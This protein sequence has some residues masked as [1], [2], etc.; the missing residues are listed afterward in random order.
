MGWWGDFTSGVENLV[1]NVGN[2]VTNTLDNVGHAIGPYMPTIAEATAAYFG[3]PYLGDALGISSTAAGATI[4]AGTSMATGGNPL[5]GAI[6]GGLGGYAGGGGFTSPDPMA[7]GA[8][9]PMISGAQSAAATGDMAQADALAQAAGFSSYQELA[10]TQTA[11]GGMGV[12]GLSPSTNMAALGAGGSGG[13]GMGGGAMMALGGLNAINQTRQ[14]QKNMQGYAAASNPLAPAQAGYAQ[15]LQ[16]LMNNP[17]GIVNMP[18]YQAGLQAVER[19]GAAGGYLG[20]GN[21][22][23]QLQQYGGNFYNNAINQYQG[24]A[25]ANASAPGQIMGNTYA[26][27]MPAYM[28]G[29]GMLAAPF[30]YNSMQGGANPMSGG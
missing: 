1:S 13:I 15:Q 4:G 30:I 9:D 29:L 7:G 8:T 24:A 17:N 27:T 14:M 3:A 20:S 28:S 18:G 2:D 21:M 26:Q 6:T 22:M 5:T 25:T 19:S 12:P 23:A 16:G 10:A 11:S